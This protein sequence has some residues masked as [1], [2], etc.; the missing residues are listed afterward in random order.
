MVLHLVEAMTSI[1]RT[2]AMRTTIA[3]PGSRIVSM[4]VKCTSRIKR[5][6][7]LFVGIERGQISKLQSMRYIEL[8][9]IERNDLVY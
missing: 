6:L 9:G 7:V 5:L 2:S 8:I 4:E 3:M 1:Y